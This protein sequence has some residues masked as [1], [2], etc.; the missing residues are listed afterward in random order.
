MTIF[1]IIT[2]PLTLVRFD[3]FPLIVEVTVRDVDRAK[4]IRCKTLPSDRFDE[5]AFS[6]YPVNA[7]RNCGKH[8]YV[9]FTSPFFNEFLENMDA[10]RV[11]RPDVSHAQDDDL[12]LFADNAYRFPKLSDRPKKQ[13][14][15]DLK[16]LD[17][18][19]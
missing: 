4:N 7:S 2:N 1:S 15:V 8:Q 19:R 9:T 11:D 12:W 5:S 6:H 14:S 10:A 16:D 17:S 3:V 18:Q 13:R